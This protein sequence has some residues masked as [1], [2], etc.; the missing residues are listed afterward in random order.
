[1]NL[2]KTE[3]RSAIDIWVEIEQFGLRKKFIYYTMCD[4]DFNVK[5]FLLSTGMQH[6]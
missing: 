6:L 4:L 3:S 1:M 2:T 5:A